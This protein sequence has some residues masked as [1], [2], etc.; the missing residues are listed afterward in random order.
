MFSYLFLFANCVL[1]AMFTFLMN[2]LLV[3]FARLSPGLQLIFQLTFQANRFT[4][5]VPS[6][7]SVFNKHA[8][9]KMSSRP[10]LSRV[11]I[12]SNLSVPPE[13]WNGQPPIIGCI[14]A[15]QS[16]GQLEFGFSRPVVRSPFTIVFRLVKQQFRIMYH[17]HF[18]NLRHRLIVVS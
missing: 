10:I 11:S 2:F 9:Q 5:H 6:G 4:C 3:R 17:F 1:F 7:K 8:L 15:R 13:I 18:P 16:S 14:A 12:V